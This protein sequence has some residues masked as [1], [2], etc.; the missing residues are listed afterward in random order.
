MICV[1]I[2]LDVAPRTVPAVGSIFALLR[3]PGSGLIFNA[4]LTHKMTYYLEIFL[5]I[6]EMQQFLERLMVSIRMEH[7]TL[8]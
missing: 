3:A 7:V 2:G 6:L 8:V 1:R 5:E 4:T